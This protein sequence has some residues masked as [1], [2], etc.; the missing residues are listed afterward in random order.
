MKTPKK[1][2]KTPKKS[3]SIKKRKILSSKVNDQIK[4]QLNEKDINYIVFEK[5]LSYVDWNKIYEILFNEK[6]YK[7][8]GHY[9]FAMSYL[10]HYIVTYE[11]AINEKMEYVEKT[12]YIIDEMDKINDYMNNLLK[13][14]DSYKKMLDQK[15]YEKISEFFKPDDKN[16][17]KLM[18]VFYKD[19][20]EF[21]DPLYN[22]GED[23]KFNN[24]CYLI[25]IKLLKHHY[26]RLL[27]LEFIENTDFIQNQ[28]EQDEDDDFIQNL[29][30][31]EFRHFSPNAK[32]KTILQNI[33]NKNLQPNYNLQNKYEI[34]DQDEDVKIVWENEGG[35]RK[36]YKNI[37][38]NKTR[39]NMKSNRF[40][41]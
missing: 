37:V 41:K 17:S 29:Y 9:L 3:Y 7:S 22:F 14:V 27:Y 16:N 32:F 34:E 25:F 20:N 31:T 8:Y 35:K 36:K 26:G 21:V 39:K 23:H 10:N 12:I 19:S 18:D 30:K 13:D 6:Y 2:Y 38:K 11:Y 33:T 15:I 28:K 1:S 40:R 4:L 24:G 5:D